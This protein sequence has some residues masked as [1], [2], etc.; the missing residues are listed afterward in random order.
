MRRMDR[1][2]PFK[3]FRPIASGKLSV[4]IAAAISILFGVLGLLISHTVSNSFFIISLTFAALQYS[5]T[6]FLK[7]ISVIDILTI[8]TAYFLRV[9]AGEAATGYHISVWLRWAALFHWHSSWLSEN[10]VQ[11][12]HCYKNMKASF[13][14]TPGNRF[15]II[16]KDYW[17]HIPQCLQIA[18]S[19]PMPS[20]HFWNDLLP[21]GFSSEIIT[22][23]FSIYPAENGSWS[24]SRLFCL[25]LCGIC[26]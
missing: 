13:P 14:V 25:A 9:Y 15:H 6:L 23:L 16:R 19:S 7:Q 1:R 22:I 12:S 20:I 26:S 5:Y 18:R 10:G 24:R 11:N 3:K 4:P 8:T 2:H 21:K 17:I